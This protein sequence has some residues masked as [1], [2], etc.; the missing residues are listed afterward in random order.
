[1]MPG[2]TFENYDLAIFDRDGVVNLPP[3]GGARYILEPEDL[4]LNK[5]IIQLIL[6]LQKGGVK[7]CVATN[8]Q[9][10]G[11]EL[12]SFSQLVRIH[13]SINF[14]IG[15]IGGAPLDFFTCVHLV[16]DK[17]ECR[18]PKPGLLISAMNNFGVTSDRTVFIGDQD[19]DKIA[20]ESAKV[21]F[22]FLTA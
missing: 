21:D 6:E 19:S 18:K 17:C 7:T 9:C 13:D 4:V 14:Q 11:K 1:M 8:Q 2:L 22:F 5:L 3:K 20:A 16:E 10:V 15:E 12:I